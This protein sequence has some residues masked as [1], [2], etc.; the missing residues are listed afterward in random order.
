MNE[1]TKEESNLKFEKIQ[2]ILRKKDSDACI[3]TSSVNQYWLCGFIFDGYLYIT[4]DRDPILFVKRPSDLDDERIIYIRKPEQIP[5][6]LQEAG[7]PLPKRILIEAD[8]LT[9][10]AANRLQAALNM[11]ELLNISDK[12]RKIRSVKSE[13]ELNQMRECAKIHSEVYQL[14]PA[15]Y[16]KGMSDLQLQIE[17]EREMRLRGSVGIFRSF[18]ENMDIFMG[19]ILAGDNAQAASPYDYALGGEGITPLLPLGANGTPLKPGTTVMVDMA[20]NYRPYMDDMTRTFAIEHAP[21][22]AYKAHE[23]SIEI[24][25]AVKKQAKAGTLCS[26]IYSLA[27]EIVISNELQ[28]YFMGTVQ[29]AKFIGHG[30]GLEINEPPVIT[31]RSKDTL[32][33]GMTIAL[34]PKFVLPGIGAVGIENTYI[35]HD[36]ELENITQCEEK[37]IVLK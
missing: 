10:N 28:P 30:V 11:P 36:E 35:V 18:G 4:A 29:Q 20:G 6:L 7:L 13:Y 2:N 14:I 34:E 15:L 26:D 37:I 5:G 33:S 3:I 8:Q 23:V 19:S 31:P 25:N 27:E 1:L 24:H 12:I 9:L 32:L 17:I 22:I 16:R 21:D